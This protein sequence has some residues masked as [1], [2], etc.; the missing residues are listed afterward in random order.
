MI[1]KPIDTYHAELNGLRQVTGSRR[2]SILREAFKDLLKSW[3][4]SND[5]KFAPDLEFV[6]AKGARV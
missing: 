4:K 3:G 6:T 2:E 1:R 5:L